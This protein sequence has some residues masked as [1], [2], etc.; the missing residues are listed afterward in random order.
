MDQTVQEAE[1]G[2]FGVGDVGSAQRAW[3]PASPWQVW[4]GLGICNQRTITSATIFHFLA[5]YQV[6]PWWHHHSCFVSHWWL[7]LQPSNLIKLRWSKLLWL[8]LISSLTNKLNDASAPKGYRCLLWIRDI[9]KLQLWLSILITLNELPSSDVTAKFLWD[10][11]QMN[12]GKTVRN[13]VVTRETY[14]RSL[15]VGVHT[16]MT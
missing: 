11:P 4:L 13:H 1:P 2:G 16:M 8:S 3:S 9:R 10:S 15:F 7:C 12:S 5:A 14:F 6:L